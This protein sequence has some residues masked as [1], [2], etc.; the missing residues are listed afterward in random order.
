M[1]PN[2]LKVEE[3]RAGG[4]KENEA[5]AAT[6]FLDLSKQKIAIVL[7]LIT[8]LV[9]VA[10]V[11]VYFLQQVLS[12]AVW[13]SLDGL[14]NLSRENNFPTY[15]SAFLLVVAGLLARILYLYKKKAGSTY[16]M[17]WLLLSFVFIFLSLDEAVQIHERL[18]K[19]SG[20]QFKFLNSGFLSFAWVIP[21]T[22]LFLVVAVYFARFVFALPKRT[23]N[24]FLASGVLY[25]GG[26]LGFEFVEGY[27]FNRY[28]FNVVYWMLATIEEVMEM[29]GVILVIYAMLDYLQALPIRLGIKN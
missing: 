12:P 17:Q 11:I 8:A 19:I 15:F 10:H 23:R 1:Q 24:L 13:D 25:I 18:T 20:E 26:A 27:V 29:T 16:S 5:I 7:F 14:F 4:E 9:V 3:K 2:D 6:N 21:Y 22:V 28:G